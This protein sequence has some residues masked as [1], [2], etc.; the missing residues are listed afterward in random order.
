MKRTIFF[1]LLFGFFLGVLIF[2]PLFSLAQQRGAEERKK[3]GVVLCGGGAKGA[4][5]IGV[6]KVL[7]EANVPVDM[8]VGTS[9]GALV[10]GLY[11]MGYSAVELDSIISNCD[12][13]YLLSDNTKRSDASFAKKRLDS[14]YI[15]KLPFYLQRVGRKEEP[16][17]SYLPGGFISGQ[18]VLNYLNGLS[19]G[20]RD[21]IDF[22]RDL[23]IPFAC[24]ATDLSSGKEIVLDEGY[25]PLA[26]RASM[27]IPGV[28]APVKIDGRVLVDGGMI[29]NFPVDVA[30]KMGAD[31]VIGVDIQEDLARPEDLKS[32]NQVL[33][34][35]IGLMGNE[36]YVD[37][38]NNTDVLIKPDV[39]G[40]SV[41]SFN[42][43]AIDSLLING[44]RA[45]NDMYDT[46]DSLAKSLG[47]WDLQQRREVDKTREFAKDT[48]YF[49]RVVIE[50]APSEQV[51]ILRSMLRIRDNV[52][53]T[54]ADI[55]GL[56]S[57]II[58]TRAFSA[59]NYSIE[60]SGNC[61]VINVTSG[62]M[63]VF[64]LGARF[65]SEEAASI[66]VYLGLNENSLVG[67]KI[68]LSG[69]LS[70]NPYGKIEYTYTP[71]KF[72]KLGLSYKIS[73]VDMSVFANKVNKNSLSFLTQ[74]VDFYL[75]NKY[76]R[77][78][79]F[80]G[81]VRLESYLFDDYIQ[82]GSSYGNNYLK[83]RAYIHY[84]FSGAMDNR[85]DRYFPNRGRSLDLD[86][87]LCHTG[88]SNNFNSFAALKFNYGGVARFSHKLHFMPMIYSRFIIGNCNEVP[89]LNFVGG[90]EQGRYLDHQLPFVGRNDANVM[91]GSVAIFRGDFRYNLFKRHYLTAK[92][93]YMVAGSGIGNLIDFK[94]NYKKIGVGLEYSYNS[95]LGPVQ[96]CVQWSD[97]NDKLSAYFSMGFSF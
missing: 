75:T 89:Y 90:L 50:G 22:R 77:N 49:K 57:K 82:M 44:E 39:T 93:N 16:V 53:M 69:R 21:S 26:M 24:V 95:N 74:R 28:F 80:M 58:G 70:Y 55:N 66:L 63:N 40:F 38:L 51:K 59:A 92:A 62:P 78:F 1:K 5:H 34:Q 3:V 85:D 87:S 47:F 35:I 65:D 56:I 81:G 37:N 83:D 60:E 11:S 17:I 6:L 94:E 73:G 67:S 19:M 43:S 20:Y 86:F 46:L 23:P 91:P 7:E 64:A 32:I 2:Y 79:N 71:V 27:A 8:V 96:F 36:K 10:G 48:F 33:S 42:K 9:I 18:N 14:K 88:F 84:F 45:A 61:L 52:V 31:I 13:G 54:G 4:A 41:F 29:N 12:W 68:G 25:L 30:R 72:A 15:I 76:M 97:L